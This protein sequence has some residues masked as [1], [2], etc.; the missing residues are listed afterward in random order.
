MRRLLI[1]LLAIVPALGIALAV[2]VNDASAQQRDPEETGLAGVA[3]EQVR[4]GGADR[5]D[6]SL[7]IARQVAEM[8]GNQLDVVVL[9]SGER[10]TDA[11]VAA[12]LAGAHGA[13][14]VLVPPNEIRADALEFMRGSGTRT[15]IIVGP[16]GSDPRHGPGRGVGAAVERALRDA[17]LSVE[18][19]AGEDRFGT[20]VA[21]ADR[22]KPGG[23]PGL[24]NGNT[25]I[26]ASGDV[27][28]DALVAGPF[29][30]LGVHPVLLTTPADLHADVADY[31]RAA[32]S[33]D[34]VRHVVVMGGTAALAEPVEE[35]IADAGMQVTRLA[36]DTRFDTAVK[37][38]EL[39]ED[40]Y[41]ATEDARCFDDQSY[42]IAR[43]DVPFDAFSAAP[44]LSR[45]CA[46]LLLTNS[47][48]VPVPTADY[49]DLMLQRLAETEGDA[50][51][52]PAALFV[53][54]GEAAVQQASLENYLAEAIQRI[55]D[56]CRPERQQEF[57][58]GFPR[59][60][61]HLPT[62]GTLRIGVLFVDFADAPA[63]ESISTEIDRN[64]RGFEAIFERSS[65]GKLDVEF[66]PHTRWLRSSLRGTEQAEGAHTAGPDHLALLN[67]AVELA[68]DDVD[69][70]RLDHVI[71]ALPSATFWL[72]GFTLRSGFEG[73]LP[74]MTMVNGVYLPELEGPNPWSDWA[75]GF[76][77]SSGRF[78]LPPLWP[79][80]WRLHRQPDPPEGKVWIRAEWGLR[81]LNS[82]FLADENDLRFRG[83]RTIANRPA[84]HA[85]TR[86]LE[87]Q[88]VL[89][90]TRWKMDWLT[91]DQ[92]ACVRRG[93]ATVE[94]APIANPGD[95]TAMAA[96]PINDHEV[97][98]LES[99]R[100]TGFDT[101]R[102]QVYSG[103]SQVTLPNLVAEGV[104]VYTV[105]AWIDSGGLPIK[106][107]GDSGNGQ[108]AG[109]PVLS[110]GES[111]VVRGYEITVT[112]DDGDTHTVQIRKVS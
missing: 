13:P 14:V 63:T 22:L 49:L 83:T 17:G 106:V 8:A 5:Y 33:R 73:P 39:V 95:G 101:D 86:H 71:V 107:A 94:L 69:F 102:A 25:V 12:P 43:A 1:G 76:F 3:V 105:D 62:T 50:D 6:T 81:G 34:G 16:T 97:I 89:A 88:E 54:G 56:A 67:E 75:A 55:A 31:L 18:R 10:W 28:A 91:P 15:A 66:V 52:R 21:V 29:A 90:W 48:A 44:L 20:S 111:I 77:L 103:D 64:L 104:F 30:A 99:R 4:Y 47:D 80:D 79:G 42:G 26:V 58:A 51:V 27:F 74:P 46:S 65:Y 57:Q 35:A 68:G 110:A 59:S 72:S 61:A 2:P 40:S 87:P 60:R 9:V 85:Y 109:F 82:Y 98:V 93:D 38:A 7:L 92:V 112:A 108:V 96:I 45:L 36:G 41:E 37:A 100:K 53:F 84:G 23:I 24:D 19:V 32:R 70:S 11:V 78:G